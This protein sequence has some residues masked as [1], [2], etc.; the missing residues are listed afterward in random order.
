MTPIAVFA[1]RRSSCPSARIA[2]R[3]CSGT[4]IAAEAQ[5]SARTLGPGLIAM[6]DDGAVHDDVIDADR[7]P[8][9]IVVGRGVEDPLRIE[10]DEVGPRAFAHDA[11]VAE[12]EP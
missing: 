7:I 1:V 2:T 5:E 4:G 9:R 11:A 6:R 8:M 12:R 3:G 10:H